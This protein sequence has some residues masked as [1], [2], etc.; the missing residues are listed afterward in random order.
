[1]YLKY[2]YFML[3][4]LQ[5]HLHIYLLN[6]ISLHLCFYYTK[7]AYLK[8]AKLEQLILCLINFNCAEVVL[9]SN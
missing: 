8:S 2:I 9:K 7:L 4:I 1:M 5:I 6:K 3:S